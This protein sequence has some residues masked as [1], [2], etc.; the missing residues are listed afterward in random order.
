MAEFHIYTGNHQVT[1]HAQDM[2]ILMRQWLTDNG[3]EFSESSNLRVGK[4]NL[5]LENFS[6]YLSNEHISNFK[7]SHPDS[8]CILLVTEFIERK[9]GVTSMNLFGGPLDAALLSF[10]HIAISLKRPD[11][12]RVRFS[13]YLR[14]LAYSPL[15]AAGLVAVLIKYF[16]LKIIDTCAANGWKKDFSDRVY[17]LGFYHTR[18]LA[19][20]R[21][22]PTIDY[23]VF[24]HP[25][26]RASIQRYGVL[27]A[28]D[29][30]LGGV[31]HPTFAGDAV[32]NGLLRGK[33]LGF[34]MSG[35]ISSYRQSC[36]AQL[37][38]LLLIY[39]L[40]SVFGSVQLLA[41]RSEQRPSEFAFALSP[42]KS[43]GWP[44]SSPL[45]TCR[46]LTI[47]GAI[48]LVFHQYQQHPIDALAIP[49]EGVKSLRLLRSFYDD[50]DEARRYFGLKIAE[51]L[52]V[53]RMNNG[54]T[55]GKMMKRFQRPTT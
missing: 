44:Y 46:A 28:N 2:F 38:R 53:A 41:H 23:F 32:V 31:V 39:G 19:L 54:E 49:F 34:S 27:A 11:L 1:G 10:M 35:T 3:Q 4:V 25:G 50:P 21:F 40:K 33:K 42:T 48:P 17:A 22:L 26:V 18:Y 51:Y 47:E 13:S 16:F 7:K 37:N 24:L 9:W 20:L 30:R 14:G 12:E 43:A 5:I 52:R 15:V 6:N 55:F 8:P 36:A 45:R 29:P